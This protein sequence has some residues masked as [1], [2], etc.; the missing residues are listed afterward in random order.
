[1]KTSTGWEQERN[2]SM[3]VA[4]SRRSLLVLGI[5]SLLPL[6][7][8]VSAAGGAQQVLT[9]EP[10]YRFDGESWSGL[11]IGKSTRDEIKRNYKTTGGQFIRAEALILTP[12]PGIAGCRRFS[13]DGG[14]TRNSSVF[15]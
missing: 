12:P 13:T 11:R 5:I 10:L 2:A 8:V 3:G 9:P 15:A 14:V 1:M 6:P 7:S 4:L